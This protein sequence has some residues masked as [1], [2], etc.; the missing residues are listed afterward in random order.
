MIE[1]ILHSLFFI[2]LT[3]QYVTSFYKKNYHYRTIFEHISHIFSLDAPWKHTLAHLNIGFI[4]YFSKVNSIDSRREYYICAEFTQIFLYVS[5]VIAFFP[6]HCMWAFAMTNKLSWNIWCGIWNG[7]PSK[8]KEIENRHQ[9][10]INILP[11]GNN[12][13]WK[14]KEMKKIHGMTPAGVTTLYSAIIK[15]IGHLKIYLYVYVIVVSQTTDE[16][17]TSTLN[18]S[19]LWPLLKT[20]SRFQSNICIKM[21]SQNRSH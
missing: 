16:Q 6:E 17:N 15:Q 11:E 21:K 19:I 4:S 10:K 14:K 8:K 12:N 18:L 9:Y 2:L 13:S 20:Y 5:I 7:E 3:L 1:I